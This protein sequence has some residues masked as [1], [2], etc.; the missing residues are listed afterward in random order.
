[1]KA[2]SAVWMFSAFASP[3]CADRATRNPQNKLLVTAHSTAAKISGN[4][5][6]L[7]AFE[8]WIS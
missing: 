3:S 1:M 5:W 6:R 2:G 7:G 8:V 4:L